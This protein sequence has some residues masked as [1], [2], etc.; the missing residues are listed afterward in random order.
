MGK[1]KPFQQMMLLLH[2]CIWGKNKPQSLLHIIYNNE[3][4]VDIDL[5]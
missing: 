2:V 4:E 1:E 3:F 5:N